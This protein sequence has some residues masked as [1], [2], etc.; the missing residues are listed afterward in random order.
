MNPDPLVSIIVPTHNSAEFLDRVLINLMEQSYVYKEIIVVDNYSTDTTPII[1]KRWA[2]DFYQFGFE[3]AMQDNFGIYKA[4][5]EL[6]Y[7]TGSDML[8]DMNYIKQAVEKINEGYDA[9]Y[10]SVLTDY[11]VEHFW[12]KVKALE[13]KCYIGDNTIESARFFKKEVWGKLGRFDE[14][15]VQIEEDFQHRLDKAG[16]KTGRIKAREYH[17][18]EEDSLVKIYKK[19]YYYGTFMKYYLKKHQSRGI[20]QLMPI[21]LSFFNHWFL[22]IKHPLLTMGLIIYKIVQYTGGILG[23]TR[24]NNNEE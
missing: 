16:Y 19:S 15:L 2:N 7:L 18:H 4:R 12:G 23:M 9:I 3:R 10:A 13:R 14:N 21:R 20:K 5:G 1:A 6:I 22:L 11:R 17:L 8:R 24:R